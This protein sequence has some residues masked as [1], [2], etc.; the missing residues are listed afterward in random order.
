M[1]RKTRESEFPITSAPL[2]LPLNGPNFSW[3]KF[4]TFCEGLISLQPGVKECHRYGGSGSKQNGIDIFAELQNGEQ[5]AFSCKQY[6]KFNKNNAKRAVKDTR[7][8]ANHYILLLSCDAS[9]TVRES[10]TKNPN[11]DVWDV[12]DISRKVR[13]LPLY[14]ARRLIETF[15]GKDWR[16]LF[17]GVSGPSPFASSEDFFQLLMNPDKLFNHNW[18]LIGRNDYLEELSNFVKSED[19]QAMII[20]GHG[21]IGKTKILQAFSNDFNNQYPDFSLRFILEGSSI[22]LENMDELPKPC[23]IIV[24]DAHHR[25][26]DDLRTILSFARREQIKIILSL[27]PY[28]LERIKSSLINAG[29][30]LRQI[31]CLKTLNKLSRSEIIELACQALGKDY[32]HLA[33]RLIAVTGDSPLLTVIG[34]RLLAEKEISPSLLENDSDFRHAALDKFQEFLLGKVEERIDPELCRSILKLISAI[35]P[36]SLDNR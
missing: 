30:D 13:E 10:I 12:E 5:W 21:G 28:A 23:T 27:R 16:R 8:N 24:D 31:K 32:E 20:T 25:N 15:F 18:R 19:L 14:E 2:T 26:N 34:G 22:S 35:S 1:S 7:Y 36:I 17:L 33:D 3:E 6:E 11:W 29:F 9:S 4:Q